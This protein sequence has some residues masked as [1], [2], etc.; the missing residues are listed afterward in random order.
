MTGPNE[1]PARTA[2]GVFGLGRMGLPVAR[3]LRTAGFRVAGYDHSARARQA[4][5]HAGVAVVEDVHELASTSDVALVVVP[6]DENVIAAGSELIDDAGRLEDVVVCSSVSTQTVVD[7][8]HLARR[9]RITVSEATMVRG[10]SAADTGSLLLYCGSDERTHGRLR[11][12][13]ESIASDIVL[14]GDLGSGQLAKMLNNL[15]LWSSVVSVTETLRM[16]VTLGADLDRM[17][18][19]LQLGSGRCWVLDTWTRPRPMPDAEH[20]MDRLLTVMQ[21]NNLDLPQVV[22]TSD[23]IRRIKAEKAAALDGAMIEASLDAFL[24]AQL[25]VRDRRGGASAST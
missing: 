12:V 24:K 4:A 19:A 20:D 11:P 2:V 16:A 22:A 7:L 14:V 8:E 17:V 15:L 10:E 6:G 21:Q 5:E 18:A 3:N 23:V 25:A 1:M 9:G 13:F